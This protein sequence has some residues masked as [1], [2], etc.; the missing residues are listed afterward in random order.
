MSPGPTSPSHLPPGREP[1][2]QAAAFGPGPAR[3]DTAC[4]PLVDPQGRRLDYLRLAVTDRCNLRCRYCMPAAG[5]ALGERDEI[6]SIDELIRLGAVFTGLGVR[7]F[8][9]TGGEPLVRRGLPTLIRSLRA[10]PSTPEVLLTTNGMLLADQL[11]E[12][13]E[14]GLRRVNLSLDSLDKGTWTSITRREGF[15]RVFAAIDLV[16]ARGLGLKVNMVV[17]PGWNDHELDDFVELTR[18]RAL[19]VRFIEPMPF[20]GEGKLCGPGI[21]G[22]EILARLSVSDVVEAEPVRAGAVEKLYQVPGY[23]GKVGIIEGHS[24]TFCGTCRRLRVDAR[25]RMRTC[26]YGK[27]SAFLRPL[28]RSGADDQALVAAIR[29]AVAGRLADGNAAE[30]DHR[31]H[32]LESMVNIGG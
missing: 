32:N 4:G 31:R 27:P 7:S 23:A 16:L 29:R 18:E 25:G 11:D 14:A 22:P 15:E 17:L 6:L 28:I 30:A 3:D 10:L 26:L 2:G 8:R 24:R 19:T 1:A 12:L 5:V 9:I 13:V 21:A 20:L